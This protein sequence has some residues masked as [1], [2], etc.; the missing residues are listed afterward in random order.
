MAH[1][2]IALIGKARSGKDTV[3]TVLT[4]HAAYTRLA[5]ADELKRAV[6][7]VDPFV[8][9]QFSQMPVRL[10]VAV[11][12]FGWETAKE[13]FPEIRRL[14]QEYGQTVRE[15]DPEFW[16]RPVQA[17]VRQGTRWNMPCV[18]ADVRYGNELAALQDEGA[19]VVRVTRPGSGLAGDAGDH[20]SETELDGVQP[21]Y[22]LRNGGTLAQLR[23]R[24]R[25]L[26][27]SLGG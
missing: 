2:H 27:E 16:V 10:S 26:Y 6:L 14:L 20:E 23:A 22:V 17:K 19:V 25:D 8:P 3:A 13:A 7:R 11:R 9:L 12:R 15:T 21:D 4:R 24:V 18:V 5:F 1:P